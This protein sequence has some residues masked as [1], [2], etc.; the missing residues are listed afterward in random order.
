MDKFC[1]GDRMVGWES[2]SHTKSSLRGNLSGDWHGGPEFGYDL[3]AAIEWLQEADHKEL[4]S[5][6]WGGEIPVIEES[7]E[8]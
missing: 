5:Y 2:G 3:K 4:G 7:E 1:L 6:L 8:N